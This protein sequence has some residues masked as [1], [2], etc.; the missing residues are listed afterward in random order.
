MFVNKRSENYLIIFVH[1]EKCGGTSLLSSS[2]RRK[3]LKHCDIIS[4]KKFGNVASESDFGRSLGMYRNCDFITG[5]CL[6]PKYLAEYKNIAIS[7]GYKPIVIT[8]IRNPVDRLLSDYAH[9]RRRG[10]VLGLDQFIDIPFKKNYICN[11][12]GGGL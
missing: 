4:S 7:K 9:A 10:E 3:G 8:S 2:R 12:W 11:F 6:Y 5:H 1:V